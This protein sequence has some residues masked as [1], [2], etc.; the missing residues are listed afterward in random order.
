MPHVPPLHAYGAH[1]CVPM[2][3]QTPAPLHVSARAAVVAPRHAAGLH[4]VPL[5]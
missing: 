2:S 4:T 3:T 1:A 5:P